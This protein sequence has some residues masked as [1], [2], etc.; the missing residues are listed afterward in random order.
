MTKT[1]RVEGLEMGVNLRWDLGETVWVVL[2]TGIL[3]RGVFGVLE[4]EMRRKEIAMLV[5]R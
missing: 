5:S 1:V 3:G 4:S 2:T